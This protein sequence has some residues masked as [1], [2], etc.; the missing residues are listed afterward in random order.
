MLGILPAF[1][2]RVSN[3]T[4]FARAGLTPFSDQLLKQQL[5]LF[6]KVALSPEGSPLRTN[7]FVDNTLMPQIGR[8]VRKVGRPRQN[9]TS[10]LIKE[11][12]SRLGHQRL[13]TLLQ[14]TSQGAYIQWRT[15]VSK[16]FAAG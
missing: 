2:S 3:A 8:F 14:D 12:R 11:G 6:G 15:E 5:V 1:L 13:H 9:W 4:V 7:T 16:S 10:E